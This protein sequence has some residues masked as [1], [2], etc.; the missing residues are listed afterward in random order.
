[1]AACGANASLIEHMAG[2]APSTLSVPVRV[3]LIE[4]VACLAVGLDSV[5]RSHVETVASP[6]LV[7]GVAA[8]TAEG[9]AELATDDAGLRR[10][11][12]PW[13]H[14]PLSKSSK[15]TIDEHV[16]AAAEP[17]DIGWGIVQRV[18]VSVVAVQGWSA[19]AYADI[20][21]EVLTSA[22]IPRSGLC[23]ITKP[24]GV[25]VSPQLVEVE[26][27]GVGEP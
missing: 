25:L 22:G 21:C 11:D 24:P 20:K 5:L 12:R 27:T 23:F 6:I 19:A 18:P 13:G 7:A 26:P 1:M 4:R 8:A 9:F 17:N 14:S 16:T 2:S 10:L 3:C 15:A